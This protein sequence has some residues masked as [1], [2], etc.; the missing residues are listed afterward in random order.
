LEKEKKGVSLDASLIGGIRGGKRFLGHEMNRPHSSIKCHRDDRI[1]Y[2]G[3]NTEEE[4]LDSSDVQIGHRHL[5]EG[6]NI[7]EETENF[8]RKKKKKVP[9]ASRIREGP[10]VAKGR[11][12][13]WRAF[14]RRGRLTDSK[15]RG[16]GDNSRKKR[17]CCHSIRRERD[18]VSG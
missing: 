14:R 15:E 1:R 12:A 8:G 4:N 6:P 9:F 2:L 11:V 10:W 7:C 17:R 5:Y 18:L 13:L 3:G 16:K